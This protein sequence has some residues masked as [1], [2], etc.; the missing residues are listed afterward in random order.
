MNNKTSLLNSIIFISAAL[1]LLY[2]CSTTANLS[3]TNLSS[4]YSWSSNS[5]SPEFVI[6]HDKK[7]T[8]Q[9]HF[10]IQ[11]KELLYKK[12]NQ[13]GK[14][15]AKIKIAYIL[16]D[17]FESEI[18]IDSL[19]S[20]LIEDK[21][22]S[23]KDH[24]LGVIN[25]NAP[26]GKN[27]LLRIQATDVYSNA[28]NETFIAINK[29]G[30]YSRQNFL[31][32]NK[33]N[34]PVFS[35]YEAPNT[36][37]KL[38]YNNS[39]YKSLHV[40][41]YISDFK[42]APPP[43]SVHTPKLFNY[44]TPASTYVLSMENGIGQINLP[45]EGFLH[46]VPE[47]ESKEGVSI[48]VFENRFPELAAPSNMIAPL[49]Y[50]TSKKEYTALM[51]NSDKSSLDEFWIQNAANLD[52]SRELIKHY[53]N[54]VEFANKTFTSYD[55]GWRTD[56]GMAYIVFGPPNV[57]HKNSTSESWIYGEDNNYL[58]INFVFTKVQNP[59]TD[60]DYRLARSATYKSHWYRAVD[61]W[62]QGRVFLNN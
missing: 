28:S 61:S 56:R 17:S 57:I 19:T 11:S 7:A 52:R 54:R 45:K 41:H 49:R 46:I 10:K 60:N 2:G 8:S 27:Y 55:Q 21:E 12:D 31:I 50:I 38:H 47:I 39:E 16:Y 15:A 9:L 14:N 53:Y 30:P 32:T 13:T 36:N 34:V 22:K 43:F 20:Y 51:E 24:I 48:F 29:I 25:L 6:Y 40:R 26:S 1:G 44:E 33:N 3:S 5:F 42:L 4:I 35:D 58:S 23:N 62:R 37:L 18:V 59:F